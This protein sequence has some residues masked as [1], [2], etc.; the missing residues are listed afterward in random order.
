MPQGGNFNRYPMLL[1]PPAHLGK[2]Q[3]HFFLDPCPDLR[4]HIG[5]PGFTIAAHRQTATLSILLKALTHLINP[6]P[7]HLK[8]SR[9]LRRPFATIQSPQY[10]IP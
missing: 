1:K 3:I 10:T 4:L 7:A 2:R 8:P 9:N 6:Y 5:N